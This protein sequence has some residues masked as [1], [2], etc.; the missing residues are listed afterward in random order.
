MKVFIEDT[1][2]N[3][4]LFLGL[5]CFLTKYTLDIKIRMRKFICCLVFVSFLYM[6]ISLYN[7]SYQLKIFIL[8]LFFSITVLLF[9]NNITGK[10]FIL[11][12]ICV[13]LY[14]LL[15]TKICSF[16][17]ELF[18]IK[19]SLFN[20][21]TTKIILLVWLISFLLTKV[22]KFLKQKSKIYNF[23]YDIKVENE[24]RT[25][26]LKAFLD[27][28]NML[29]D[30]ISGKPVIII[31]FKTLSELLPKLSLDDLLLHKSITKDGYFID[32]MTVGGSSKM[33]VFKPNKV[34]LKVKNRLEELDVVLGV[35]IKG[36][37]RDAYFSALLNPLAIKL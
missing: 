3:V 29:I 26:K 37:G 6:F 15:V 11:E 33:F 21:G 7:F 12:N 18:D 22:I 27:T 34:L 24:S 5:I 14:Y 25:V 13:T 19:F 31:N 10:A 1:F 9:S 32:Y 20:K 23:I 2:L 17:S 16:I 30:N 35:S 36:F 4:F 28:G 8:F